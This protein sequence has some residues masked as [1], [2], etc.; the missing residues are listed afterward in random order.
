MWAI[1]R[2][3][4]RQGDTLPEISRLITVSEIVIQA[5]DL[6]VR[7]G[8][9]EALK[10]VHFRVDVGSFV[11]IIGPN[12]SGKTSLIK[13]FLGILKPSEGRARVF[14]AAPN[15]V[16]PA[17][18]GYVPQVKT[19]ERAFPALALE[20]VLSGARQTWPGRIRSAERDDA[21]A[22]LER[23]G[24]GHLGDRPLD[25]LSGGELQR[26]FLARSLIRRPEL[27]MLDEPAAGIDVAG[28]SD[29][30]DLLEEYQRQ[31]TATV[32]MVTHDWHVAFHHATH[33]LL[34]H[35]TQIGFGLPKDVLTETNLRQ[36]FGHV[37]HAHTMVHAGKD[38]EA[39][40]RS[41]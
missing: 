34:L 3:S 17:R 26:V 12:G 9:R 6:T 29:L 31:R 4:Y 35:R 28:A 11:A 8:Q 20:L 10:R 25:A 37:G 7:F 38:L 21:L 36:A 14:G 13:T 16:D 41:H 40:D 5:E 24:A 22:A 18:I 19:L 30:Y 2:L 27:V 32:L 15:R 1:E 39:N 23:V 33:V